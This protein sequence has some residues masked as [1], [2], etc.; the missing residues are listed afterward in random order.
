MAMR[1]PKSRKTAKKT[2]KKA[3]K[4]AARKAPKKVARKATRRVTTKATK[5][6]ARKAARKAPPKRSAAARPA[7]APAWDRNGV[8]THTE[9]ASADPS[10]TRDWCA[11]VLGWKFGESMPTPAG[12]YHM[13]RFDNGT[14]GGIRANN[15]PE[16]PGSIP[17][18]EVDDI[19]AAYEK[20]LRAGAMAMMPPEQLPGGMGWIAI[21]AAPGGVAFGFWGMR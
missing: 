14:G 10:A 1:R 11:S 17:Y 15:P 20:A 16:V 13:W 4:K 18:C 9:L 2:A 7:A 12:P 5:R 6:V 21:V 19:Q 3:T 8:I